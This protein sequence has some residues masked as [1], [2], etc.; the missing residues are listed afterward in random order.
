MKQQIKNFRHN[1]ISL[2]FENG[3][4]IDAVFGYGTYSDN[5]D[6]GEFDEFIEKGS[7][8]V[9]FIFDCGSKLEKKIYKKYGGSSDDPMG[10][11]PLEDWLDIAMLI[12]NEKK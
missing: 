4:S 10:Y 5:H 2:E 3:N 9:E 11:I 7:S 8:T 1:S 6:Y 12:K